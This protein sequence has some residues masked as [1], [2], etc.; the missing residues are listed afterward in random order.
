MKAA[1]KAYQVPSFGNH[2]NETLRRSGAGGA[3]GSGIGSEEATAEEL[4]ALQAADVG[5]SAGKSQ[6]RSIPHCN[7]DLQD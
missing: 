2:G 4:I 1:L 5:D 6:A 3:S 7:Q